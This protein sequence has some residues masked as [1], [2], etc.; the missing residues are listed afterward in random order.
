[1]NKKLDLPRIL[2]IV[3]AGVAIIAAL[4]TAVVSFVSPFLNG[5]YR[6]QGIIVSLGVHAA[7]LLL[8]TIPLVLIAVMVL[9]GKHSSPDSRKPLTILLVVY[10]VGNLLASLISS[11]L[12]V[13][14]LISS[15]SV[16]SSETIKHEILVYYIKSIGGN[17]FGALLAIATVVF[18]IEAVWKKIGWKSP[19]ALMALMWV[20]I[21]L[22]FLNGINM[23]CYFIFLILVSTFVREDA[24]TRPEP[25]T[26]GYIG[27]FVALGLALIAYAFKMVYTVFQNIAAG[28][29]PYNTDYENTISVLNAVNTGLGILAFVAALTIPLI[30]LGKKLPNTEE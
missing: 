29:T 4:I 6:L 27:S 15:Y 17:L 3:S 14:S 21:V 23:S 8:V 18:V 5:F 20:L 13:Y 19:W 9:G 2:E 7:S 10:G 24:D 11:G 28:A 1:M 16:I 22:N 12:N 25:A 30:L 26:G